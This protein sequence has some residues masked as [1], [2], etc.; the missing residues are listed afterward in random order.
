MGTPLHNFQFG[1]PKHNQALGIVILL[2]HPHQHP[3]LNMC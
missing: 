2:M 3:P 1:N